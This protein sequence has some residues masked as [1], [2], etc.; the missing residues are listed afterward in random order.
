MQY[1]SVFAGQRQS[2]WAELA[3]RGNDG[4]SIFESVE[5]LRSN[6]DSGHG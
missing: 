4:H 3:R 1:E 5:S 6:K 2:E